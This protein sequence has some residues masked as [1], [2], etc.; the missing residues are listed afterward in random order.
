MKIYITQ[1]EI[2]NDMLNIMLKEKNLNKLVLYAV[3][4]SDFLYGKEFGRGE[5]NEG[6]ILDRLNNGEEIEMDLVLSKIRNKNE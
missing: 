5:F 3:M 2:S 4:H 1:N 6:S